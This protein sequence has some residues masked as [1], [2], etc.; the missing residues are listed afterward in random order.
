MWP[1]AD[2]RSASATNAKTASRS[3]T[4]TTRAWHQP[5]ASEQS[6]CVSASSS[7]ITS[8]AHTRAPRVANA[9]AIARPK[10]CAAPVTMTVLS[11][12]VIFTG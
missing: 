2:A 10:P 7:A 8:Q 5:P 9:S 11:G 6:F 12:N 4:S 1:L 3:L